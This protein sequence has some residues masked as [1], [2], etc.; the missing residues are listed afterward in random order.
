[1]PACPLSLARLSLVIT[2]LLAS[3]C[4]APPVTP[5][6][7][8]SAHGLDQ[9]FANERRPGAP[10]MPT[11]GVALA[12]GGTKAAGF[13]LGVL[14]GLVASGQ[15]AHVQVISSVSG[16]SYAAYWYYARLV[17]DDPAFEQDVPTREAFRKSMFLDCLPSR[18]QGVNG[19][20]EEHWALGYPPPCPQPN[21]T[22]L[23]M[24]SADK[25]YKDA[26]QRQ[27]D[28]MNIDRALAALNRPELGKDPYRAQ[29]Y[30]RGYQDIFSTGRNLFGAH[31]FDYNTTEDDLRFIN[32]TVEMIPLMLG[33]IVLNSVA[34]LAFDW[35]INLSS[36]Q[37]AYAKGIERTY[38]ASA[39]DCELQPDACITTLFGNSVRLQGDTRR[40]LSLSFAQLRR[41]YEVKGAPLWIINATAGED[42]SVLDRHGQMDFALS[43]FEMGAYQ[44][45]SGLYGYRTGQLDGVTPA[46]AV[47]A[48]AAFL[49][50]QQKVKAEPPWRNLGNAL[51]KLAAQDWGLSV[52]NPRYTSDTLFYLH[53]LLPFPL[54]HADRLADASHS[55]YLHLSDG[56]MSENLGA[57]A[58]V[59]R[60]VSTLIISDHSMDRA[61]W[62][63]DICRLKEGLEGQGLS[64]LL[65]GLSSLETQCRV[66]KLEATGYDIHAWEHPVLVGCIVPQALAGQGCE[67]LPE[68]RRDGPY[69]A[70]VFVIKPSLGMPSMREHVRAIGQACA[71]S[72]DAEDCLD[73]VRAACTTPNSLHDGSPLWRGAAAAPCEVFGFIGKNFGKRGGTASD[74]CPHYPQ[75]NTATVTLDSSPWIYGAMRELAAYYTARIRWFF[76]EGGAVDA[77]RFAEEL[78]YQRQHPL[79][80]L[81]DAS[82]RRSKGVPACLFE[83][84]ALPAKTI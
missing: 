40:A 29:N 77:Q 38:G 68:N 41:A 24:I 34:N 49:D 10:S 32:E 12:G 71:G 39:P 46:R 3:A 82:L 35:N 74:G 26:G 8:L 51:L 78:R 17:L 47:A 73:A 2:F 76:P 18:Y 83:P 22:N 72:R 48:S 16:G 13:S 7:D 11:L 36:T 27:H 20:S 50:S 33:S 84:R 62:M 5:R 67:R 1:M 23:L 53:H 75:Y 45:G 59:R 14:K 79:P 30:L 28:Q 42:R 64:L 25:T 37:H 65:P 58:L 55:T 70:R 57:Y 63:A 56:G 52:R 31:A 6:M 15:M 61:G 9:R 69:S 60:R 54:Y 80:L 21:N 43:A 66:V 81:V 4:V 19:P 44:Y